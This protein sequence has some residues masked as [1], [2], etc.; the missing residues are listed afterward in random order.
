MEQADQQLL[1]DLEELEAL[2]QTSNVVKVT[3]PKKQNSSAPKGHT[4]NKDKLN[5][6]LSQDVTFPYCG[7]RI[8]PDVMIE[9]KIIFARQKNTSRSIHLEFYR[10]LL[11][12]NNVD[13]SIIDLL[14][15]PIPQFKKSETKA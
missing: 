9:L 4:E 11:K 8:H 13:Q 2:G 1:A 10:E 15:L 12:D 14:K 7:T 6:S 3:P 5:P